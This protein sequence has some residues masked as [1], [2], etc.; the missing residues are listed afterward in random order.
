VVNVA[1]CPDI[2]VGFIPF[3]LCA[4]HELFCPLSVVQLSVVSCQLSANF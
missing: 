2:D 4:C 3:K 1:N